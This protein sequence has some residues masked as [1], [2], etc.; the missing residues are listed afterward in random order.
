MDVTTALGPER[1]QAKGQRRYGLT[2]AASV[3]QT[4][5]LP[6]CVVWQVYKP[7]ATSWSAGAQPVP[8]KLLLKIVLVLVVQPMGGA[9]VM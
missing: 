1:P 5:Y 4:P 6:A 9:D 7:D 3:Q 8:I 2:L